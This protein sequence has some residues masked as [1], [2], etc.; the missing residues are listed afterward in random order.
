MT[1]DQRNEIV[2]PVAGLQIWCSDCLEDGGVTQ[3]FDGSLWTNGTGATGATGATG[4]HGVTGATG[5]HGVTGATGDQGVTG[6]TGDNGTNGTTGATGDQGVTGDNGTT[7]N[8]GDQGVTGA[9]GATGTDG[10]GAAVYTKGL[11]ADLGGYVFWLTPDGKHGLVAETQNSGRDNLYN[12]TYMLT[13]SENHSAIGS[14]FIDWRLPTVSEAKEMFKSRVAIGGFAGY[15]WS[16]NEMDASY[17]YVFD[18]DFGF[19]YK[20][21]KDGTYYVRGV[22]AF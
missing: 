20:G 14:N 10:A 9:T 2:E 15:Y 18:F 6:A 4:D 5:D 19:A 1:F 16:S 7:G 17:S 11:N 12:A 8:T 22:R 3:I 13:Q 21:S